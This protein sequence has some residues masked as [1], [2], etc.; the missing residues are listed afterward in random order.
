VKTQTIRPASLGHKITAMFLFLMT[1]VFLSVPYA[2]SRHPGEP[3]QKV[4]TI[5]DNYAN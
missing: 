3:L 5:E 2:I 1:I 4:V